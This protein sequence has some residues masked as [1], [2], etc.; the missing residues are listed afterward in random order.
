MSVGKAKGV[1]A[2]IEENQLQELTLNFGPD[3]RV[4]N[5]PEVLRMLAELSMST[6]NSIS[7]LGPAMAAF[8][9]TTSP[10]LARA[11]Q[12]T[13]N[14][15]K[16][17][18]AEYGMLTSMDVARLIGSEKSSRSL[19]A[20]QRSAGKL[21]GIKRGNKYVYPGFQFDQRARRVH[22]AIPGLLQM[23]GDVDWDEEDLI[24]W[25]VSPSGYFHGDRP[26][27]HLGDTDLADK[28]RQS[29]TVEW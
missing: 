22:P 7:A 19:A 26:V 17:I 6:V 20:D 27:D 11:V 5:T 16:G 21:I 28:G 8:K 1:P 4:P 29:A 15:W 9:G 18:E 10:Q 12:A 24:F 13:E 2:A 3:I 14:V 25:L 23:A